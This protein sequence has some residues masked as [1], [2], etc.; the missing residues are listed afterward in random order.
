MIR[1]AVAVFRRVRGRQ[2]AE[3]GAVRVI[4]LVMAIFGLWHGS[5]WH[6]VLFG[7]AQGL[8]I[9]GWAAATKGTRAS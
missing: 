2:T 5:A 6:F 4:L 3:S 7:I 1:S 9:A 8:V